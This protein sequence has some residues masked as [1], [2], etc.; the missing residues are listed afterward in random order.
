[1]PDPKVCYFI[2]INEVN[3]YFNVWKWY[4]HITESFSQNESGKAG[5]RGE[6]WSFDFPCGEWREWETEWKTKNK[7]GGGRR[8]PTKTF[9]PHEIIPSLHLEK[10]EKEAGSRRCLRKP[11]KICNQ[12]WTHALWHMFYGKR[13]FKKEEDLFSKNS[14]C[15]ALFIIKNLQRKGAKAI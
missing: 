15:P 11:R 4:G 14:K 9:H 5:G 10:S 8:L 6:E 13:H 1:M 2:I 12:N 7:E 3:K